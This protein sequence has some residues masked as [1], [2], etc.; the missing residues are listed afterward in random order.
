MKL[1]DGEK[2]KMKV[3]ENGLCKISDQYFV[4]FKRPNPVF[5]KQENRP[6]YLAIRNGN[7]IVWLIPLSSRI[8]KYRRKAEGEAERYG[9]SLFCHIARVKG[10]DSAFLIGNAIPVTE[11]YILGPFTVSGKP[12]V[13]QDKRDVK[14]IRSKLSRYLAMVRAGKLR[15]AVDILSIERILLNRVNNQEFMV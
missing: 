14:A 10:R 12:F 8:E 1:R 5:N 6:Y 2:R 4:D 11:E 13:I 7:G 3:S 9:D 15:P